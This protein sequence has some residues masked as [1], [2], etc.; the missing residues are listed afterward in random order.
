MIRNKTDELTEQNTQRRADVQDLKTK[1][2][3]FEAQLGVFQNDLKDKQKSL[4]TVEDLGKKVTSNEVLVQSLQNNVNNFDSKR[5][6]DNKRLRE[7]LD[8]RFDEMNDSVKSVNDVLVEKLKSLNATTNADDLKNAQTFVNDT[9]DF[10]TKFQK[11]KATPEERLTEA[12]E[13][14]EKFGI[15]VGKM[16]IYN[17]D[18]YKRQM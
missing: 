2:S 10:Y 1:Q 11:A 6:T 18:V 12:N 17:R 8:K 4:N 15:T 5:L 9:N 16:R 3:S 13:Y 7:T 14:D